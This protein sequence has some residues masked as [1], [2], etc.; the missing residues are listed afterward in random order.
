MFGLGPYR[1]PYAACAIGK[2]RRHL[3]EPDLSRF[4]DAKWDHVRG[5][6]IA[7]AAGGINQLLAVSAIVE[8]DDRR[9]APARLAVGH[10]CGADLL[11]HRI[12]RR[13]FVARSPRWT[14]GGA[15]P[16][17][18]AD[19]GIDGNHI[20]R[21]CD[22][23]RRA[24]VEA[25]RAPRDARAGMGAEVGAEI[26]VSGLIESADEMRGLGDDVGDLR[27]IGRIGAEIP[28]AQVRGGERRRR[29]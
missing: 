12:G 9:R 20:A 16:A 17:P 4:A 8:Q 5:Q 25:A 3:F 29:P 24:H 22:S 21:G 27:R 1:D 26:D 6:P 14:N 28:L 18:A 11:H 15:G 10:E 23:A 2:G 13:H 19:V 7:I